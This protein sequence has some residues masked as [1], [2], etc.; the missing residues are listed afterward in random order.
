ML[1]LIEIDI[2]ET[3]GTPETPIVRGTFQP[4]ASANAS[5]Q[6]LFDAR[7]EEIDNIEDDKDDTEA[8]HFYISGGGMTTHWFIV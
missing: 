8:S 7:L 3:S 4:H 6:K 2:E 5:M 1:K